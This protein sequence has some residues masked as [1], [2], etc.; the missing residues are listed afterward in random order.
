M[1]VGACTAY[2]DGEG[3]RRSPFLRCLTSHRSAHLGRH[4]Q[5]PS[6]CYS[7]AGVR[8]EESGGA[9]TFVLSTHAQTYV[10]QVETAEEMEAWLRVLGRAIVRSTTVE[11]E[12]VGPV[13]FL[14][15]RSIVWRN[16]DPLPGFNRV[17]FA[18]HRSVAK[19]QTVLKR[20]RRVSASCDCVPH[21]LYHELRWAAARQSCDVRA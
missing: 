18:G 2:A 21:T 19:P 13:S 6:A 1:H 7:A 11:W 15:G 14:A 3:L 16:R 4:V 9:N 17:A 8:R 20:H 10:L 12:S 5:H